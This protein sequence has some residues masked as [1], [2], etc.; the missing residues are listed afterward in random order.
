VKDDDRSDAAGTS[1]REQILEG[2]SV[3]ATSRHEVEEHVLGWYPQLA[4]RRLIERPLQLSG[5]GE[6]RS[7]GEHAE[8]GNEPA[9]AS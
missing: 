9:G 2:H 6:T 1:E 3:L 8:E 7:S 4:P 5:G